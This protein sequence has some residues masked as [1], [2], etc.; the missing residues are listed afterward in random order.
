LTWR[1]PVALAAVLATLVIG[2]VLPAPVEATIGVDDYP[3]NLKNAAQD[4][5]VDPW[6]FYNRE[7]T[8]FVAWRLSHDAGIAFHNWYKGHH[9]GDAAIWKQ[10]ALA[11]GV[12]V[13][14]TPRVGAIAW[15]AMGSAGS[16]RGHVAWVVA[17]DSSSIT[18]EE[19]NYLH[20]GGYDRRT[21][22]R[23]AS[24]RPTAYIHLGDGADAALKNTGSPTVSGT[25][26]VGVKLTASPGTWTPSGGTYSYQWY[27][28]GIAITGATHPTFTP[29]AEQLGKQLRVK[30]TATKT[31]AATGTA[32]SVA[33]AATAPGVLTATAPPT[34]AGT[35]QVGVQLSATTGAWSPAASYTYQWRTTEGRIPG[36][37]A[38]TFTPT[39]EQ[40]DQPLQVT[41]TAT[42]DGYRTARSTSVATTAVQSGTFAAQAPPTITGDAQVD[43]TLVA[44]PGTWSPD[45]PAAYQ[46]LVDGLPVT[47][48]TGPTYT[49]TAD[50]VRKQVSVQVSVSLPGYRPASATSSATAAV[51]PGTFRNTSDPFVTGTAKVGVPLSADPG[52]WSPE[53]T[54]TWQWTA[55]GAPIPGATSSSFTPSPAELGKHLVVEVTA[56]RP[57]YLTAMIESTAT[58]AVLPGA[59]SVTQAPAIT[60]LPH[61]GRTL[62]ATPGTWAVAPTS[63]DYQWYADGVAIANATSSAFT[64]TEAQLDQRLTVRVTAHADGYQPRTASSSSTSPVLLGQAAF[65]TTPS[66]TGTALVGH[67]LTASPGQFTPAGGTPTYQWLRGGVEISGATARTYVLQPADV[68]HSV[69][70][71]VTVSAPQWAP[72]TALAGTATQVRSVPQLTV[73]VA[74]HATWAGVSVHVVTPGLPDPDGKARLYEHGR[75]L[76]TIVVTD[77]RGYLRLDNLR[78]RTHRVA[79]RYSGPGP[80]VPASTRVDIAIG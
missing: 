35:P 66:L 28:G 31:G 5:L 32:L 74:G 72:T 73:R 63:V 16:S 71:R 58:A 80:L 12:P 9:W 48:A 21:I 69:A 40:L 8:S 75:L 79:V 43:K 54:L 70:V 57:G 46:W 19:Y 37:T 1:R 59:N 62:T 3:S 39:A 76:G 52:G 27:A 50:D 56:R 47:G 49:P 45:A 10:A 23:T 15:W 55:D 44:S 61:V 34:I 77:G 67:T 2:L 13:D 65:T 33:T 68:G 41:V 38:S 11:S 53:P 4:S 6:N 60:G 64:P 7:C 26:Q 25:P 17:V 36:A 51:I 24:Y 22:S 18:V 29:R 20:R 78:A 30:V 42:R 14:G